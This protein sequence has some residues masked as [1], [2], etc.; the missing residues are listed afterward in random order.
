MVT[1]SIRGGEQPNRILYQ[2]FWLWNWVGNEVFIREQ[3]TNTIIIGNLGPF[4][5]KK[6]VYDLFKKP[7]MPCMETRSI[8]Y[9]PLYEVILS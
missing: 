8:S 3:S 5:G 1:D 4:S 2:V 7:H 9:L 6:P